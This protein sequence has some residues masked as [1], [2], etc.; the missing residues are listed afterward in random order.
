MHVVFRF[1]R[2]YEEVVSSLEEGILELCLCLETV[3]RFLSHFT[4][5]ENLVNGGA[6]GAFIRDHLLCVMCV[7][8]SDV[9]NKKRSHIKF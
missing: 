2:L 3:P 9:S 8:K 5:V 6:D 4:L 1:L 7:K